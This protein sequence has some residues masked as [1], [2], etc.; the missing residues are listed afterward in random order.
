MFACSCHVSHDVANAA[1]TESQWLKA[2]SIDVVVS[3]VV[4]LCCSAAR[5]VGIPSICVSNF[6][7]GALMARPAIHERMHSNQRGCIC[8][9]GIRALGGQ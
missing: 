1:Q 4:P 5:A 7:W 8:R 2:C 9:G 3:D 6:S